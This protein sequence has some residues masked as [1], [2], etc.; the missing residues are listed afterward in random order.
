[1]YET[2]DIYRQK[3]QILIYLH[4][5]CSKGMQTEAK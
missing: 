5:F 4:Y 3:F 2:G 1:M